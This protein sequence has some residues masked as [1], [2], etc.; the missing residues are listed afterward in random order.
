MKARAHKPGHSSAPQVTAADGL[1]RV[2][3][4]PG[5]LERG[6]DVIR[7]DDD[8]D[9]DYEARCNLVALLGDAARNS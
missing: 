5:L 3:I 7:D 2:I 4:V 1:P 8:T 9:A 6:H